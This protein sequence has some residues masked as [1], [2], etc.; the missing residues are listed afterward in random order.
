MTLKNPAVI[1]SAYTVLYL[2]LP[3]LLVTAIWNSNPVRYG[4]V[5]AVPM[6]LGALAYTM[7]N[8]QLVLASRP[9][10]LERWFGMDHLYRIHGFLAAGAIA[11]ALFHHALE[12][13]MA[14]IRWLS[15]SGDAALILFIITS[16]LAVLFLTPVL[17]RLRPLSFLYCAAHFSLFRY[18]IQRQIHNITVI[19]VIILF[20]HV[21][22]TP[23]ARHLSVQSIYI[24]YFGTA[25]SFYIYHRLI[26]PRFLRSL[27]TVDSVVPESDQ[28]TTVYMHPVQNRV[29]PYQPGQ[30]G[31]FSFQDPALSR[32]EHP[33]SITSQPGS[34]ILS[35]TVK[36]LGDWTSR[37]RNISPGSTVRVD[38]PYG[39]LSPLL[40]SCRSGIILIA[41]GAGIT[42]MLSIMR[43]YRK[44]D[45][46]QKILLLWM[47][48]Y[49][50]E[51]ICR[52][53]W[54]D[55][56]QTMENFTFVPIVSRDPSFPGET[57]HITVPLIRRYTKLSHIDL[58]S[59][60]IFICGPSNM[61]DACIDM[62]HE[63]QIKDDLI[64]KENFSF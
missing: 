63:L 52:Q 57:G 21:M 64:H 55:M 12:P 25:L 47:I 3:L 60:Q 27:F 8:M 13:R 36:N 28:M 6:I 40:Y 59:A 34:N 39:R 62:L 15:P 16:L 53:E 22:M 50:K 14:F 31:Y 9:R 17:R 49:E 24:L 46:H 4:S 10:W 18:H 2:F 1:R 5:K 32:E 48:P 45:P 58:S 51:L 23:A 41:A 20:L 61:Q 29:F 37:V 33:F 35:V 38:A 26:R 56:Q 7:M 44:T 42:P 11:A 30:F 19:A 43:Y 54:Q